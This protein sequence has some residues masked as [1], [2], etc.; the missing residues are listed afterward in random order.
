[1]L[2][3]DP[4]FSRQSLPT[5]F[6]RGLKPRVKEIDRY[7][8]RADWIV[9]G[10]SHFDHASDLPYIVPKTGATVIGNKS[11]GVLFD[12]YGLPKDKYR[13]VTGG[14]T[15]EAGPFKL[16]FIKSLHGKFL[17]YTPFN[18]EI[19]PDKKAP[20][21][22]AG[23]GSGEVFAILIE[24]GGYKIYHHGSGGLIDETLRG[25]R[26]DLAIIGV[27]SRKNF[28]RMVYRIVHELQP[29]VVIPSHYDWFF[30]PLTKPMKFVPFINFPQ[31][32][33]ETREAAPNARL[34]T[35]PFLGEYRI[36]TK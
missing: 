9:I 26:A 7:M 12:I 35:L 24:V 27:S 20:L 16:T 5:L 33:D 10:H 32:V 30:K 21:N 15:V 31:V 28:P 3:V 11:V 13:Q 17:G 14:D 36:K 2:W 29:S 22:A 34:I 23:Y 6:T 25:N 8:D 1:V 19:S 4:F 18:Y